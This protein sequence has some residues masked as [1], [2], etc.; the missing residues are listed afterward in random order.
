MDRRGNPPPDAAS[1]AIRHVPLSRTGTCAR[2]RRRVSSFGYRSLPKFHAQSATKF[3]SPIRSEWL[4]RTRAEAQ[5]RHVGHPEDFVFHHGMAHRSHAVSVLVE[6]LVWPSPF[7]PAANRISLRP[8][9]AA[10]HPARADTS[11]RP[12]V[13]WRR[14]RGGEAVVSRP[15]PPG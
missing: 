13:P 6:H 10:P 3:G 2:R 14:R 4:S 9:K 5:A 15:N 1:G 11:G 8:Q 12:H 7:R